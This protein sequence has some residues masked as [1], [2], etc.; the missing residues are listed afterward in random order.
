M[1]LLVKR[2][3]VDYTRQCLAGLHEAVLGRTTRGSAWQDYTRQCL[4]GLHE[5]VLGR[6]TRGSAW[7]D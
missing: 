1:S 5:A 7:Q 2:L 3:K 6:T 4:A